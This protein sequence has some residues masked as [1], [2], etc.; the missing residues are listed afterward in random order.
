M[1]NRLHPLP[2]N[3]LQAVIA[4]ERVGTAVMLLAHIQDV[5]GSNVCRGRPILTVWLVP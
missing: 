2:T 3:S 4:S 5:P 1:N